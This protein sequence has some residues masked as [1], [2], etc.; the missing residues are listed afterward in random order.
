MKKSSLLPVNGADLLLLYIPA[1]QYVLTAM[2][3]NSKFVAASLGPR[4]HSFNAIPFA[5]GILY[6]AF[7]S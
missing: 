1:E 5:Y 3:L 6:A 7:S 4:T 2:I